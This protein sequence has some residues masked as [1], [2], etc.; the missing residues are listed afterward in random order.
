ME[1]GKRKL[2]K[3]QIET[4]LAIVQSLGK[5]IYSPIDYVI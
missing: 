3:E 1:N 4:E 5:P 2:K